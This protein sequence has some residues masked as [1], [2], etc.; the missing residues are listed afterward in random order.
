MGSDI[1]MA[2]EPITIPKKAMI[3]GSIR[4]VSPETAASASRS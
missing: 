4:E 1:A 3:I 2:I